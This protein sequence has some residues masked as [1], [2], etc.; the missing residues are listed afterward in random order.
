MTDL[1]L[2]RG[3]AL[4]VERCRAGPNK[5]RALRSCNDVHHAVHAMP[6][7]MLF[8]PFLQCWTRLAPSILPKVP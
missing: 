5:Q 1:H 8:F 7:A 4:C 3:E 6:D 2:T